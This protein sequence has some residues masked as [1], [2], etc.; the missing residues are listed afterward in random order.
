MLL[1]ALRGF[2]EAIL[3]V[4][5]HLGFSTVVAEGTISLKRISDELELVVP[6]L[7]NGEFPHNW[8]PISTA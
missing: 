3:A 2:I 1:F 6:H 4:C 5:R 8:L 7:D